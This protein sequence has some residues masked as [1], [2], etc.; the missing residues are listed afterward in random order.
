MEDDVGHIA[1]GDQSGCSS[2]VQSAVMEQLVASVILSI[3]DGQ[4]G[5][6]TVVGVL[7]VKLQEC[8]QDQLVRR[9]G[10]GPMVGE[11]VSVV[12]KQRIHGRLNDTRVTRQ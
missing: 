10:Y 9:H 5:V 4:V 12:Q 2:Q 7:Q 3:I 11:W 6:V 8:Y 1:G